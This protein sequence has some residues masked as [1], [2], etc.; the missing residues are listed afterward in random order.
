MKRVLV[1]DDS[2]T[3]TAAL[4]R[5]LEH[6]HEIDVVGVC[7]SAEAALAALPEL[8]PDLV[9]MDIELPGMSGLDAVE[10]IM[11]ARPLPI[12]VISSTVASRVSAN[13]AA[14]LAAGALDVLP[15]DDLDLGNPDG[16][17]AAALRR[18]VKLLSGARVI[19]HPRARLATKTTRARGPVRTA[20]AI[21]VCASTGGPQALAAV[22]RLLPEDHPVP[23]LVVQHIGAGFTAGF[24]KWLD[25]E[26]GLRVET[27]RAGEQLT[28][29]VWIAPEGAH[30]VVTRDH[31]LALDRETSNLHRPS[32]DVLLRSLADAVGAES[33]GVVLTGMGRDGAEGLGAIRAAGGLT[34]AQDEQTSAVYGMPAAAAESAELILPPQAIGEQLASLRPPGGTT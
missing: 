26:I 18:R 23:I 33:A 10:Q 21:G 28:R 3:Y 27:A 6:D 1:C 17:S 30:L 5:V 22:L 24:A 31:T 9:T 34:V 25:G 13:V 29:G 11:G 12:L 8:N 32:G 7:S 19:R 15:K 16:T 2:K 14:A 20:R 4:V